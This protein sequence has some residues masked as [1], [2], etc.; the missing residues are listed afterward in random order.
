V[1]AQFCFMCGAPTV[2]TVHR[3][4][5]ICADCRGRRASVDPTLCEWMLQRAGDR[6]KGPMT[7]QAVV[8]ALARDRVG[9]DDLVG[10]LGG[11][12][13]PLADHAD[14]R[15]CWIPGSADQQLIERFQVESRRT[16]RRA[17]A[18]HRLRQLGAVALLTV[19]SGI[20]YIGLTSRMFVAPG[21][22]F[23][24]A[25][26][27]WDDAHEL[28]ATGT[29]PKRFVYALPHDEW[30]RTTVIPAAEAH[31][32]PE[33]AFLTGRIALWRGSLEDRTLAY[34]DLMAA[35]G[36]SPD[37]PEILSVF[38]EAAASLRSA[39]PEAFADA[40][41]AFG[42]LEGIQ[43]ESVAVRRAAAALDL[44]EGNGGRAMQRTEACANGDVPDPG[45]VLLHGMASL[46]VG[47][48]R[49]LLHQ[50]PQA[51]RVR[52]AL[53]RAL[54]ATGDQVG[55]DRQS[56][57]LTRRLPNEGEG[58]A[59][60][61]EACAATGRWEKA[62][63]AADKA[64]ERDP[65]RI[66][67]LHLAAAIALRIER[68][69]KIAMNMFE[70]L[71]N[72]P[73][74]ESNDR[75][76]DILAQGADAA[77][78]ADQHRRAKRWVDEALRDNAHHVGAQL[79]K[80][81]VHLDEGDETLAKGVLRAIEHGSDGNRSSA[82][83]HLW[84]GRMYLG[85]GLQRSARTELDSAIESDPLLMEPRR[86]LAWAQLKTGDLP[87]VVS[88]IHQMAWLNPLATMGADPRSLTGPGTPPP[89][90]FFQALRR[91]LNS[92]V[93][94]EPERKPTLALLAWIDGRAQ[95]LSMLESAVGWEEGR[96]ELH[97]ALAQEFL[98]RKRW[99][100]AALHAEHVVQVRPNAG[101]FH[102][103]FGR[104][105]SKQGAPVAS[106]AAFELALKHAGD[107][108]TVLWWAIEARRDQG[109]GPGARLLLER[110]MAAGVNTPAVEGSLLALAPPDE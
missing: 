19:T 94:M 75:R 32:S 13:V 83:S 105:M 86:E 110:L 56:R 102:A 21:S 55:L 22:W 50:Y 69:P 49:E 36:R 12:M 54:L 51:N 2:T 76:A 7:R 81:A 57:I 40:S 90:E 42:R 58:H 99:R 39:S 35:V 6:S 31:A 63:L 96:V 106:E 25:E 80:A 93:R 95:A 64:V 65:W 46:D 59:L 79:T 8:H 61:A 3:A 92:D 20:L 29:S 14:F 104:A 73:R 103:V 101:L 67:S 38:V 28:L 16:L 17:R 45:C 34:H 109:D 74:F 9:P 43:V 53:A 66:E 27:W 44:V 18:R 47:R 98:G 68:R 84:V 62:R 30:I 70:I 23:E 88:T 72:H 91:A 48:L 71:I 100:A 82:W 10:R 5:P 1:E 15:A 52:L 24:A 37:D 85:L 77:L 41:R 108:P 33:T 60:R 87:G 26:S 107:D 4:V 97:A 78:Q 11:K 89:R